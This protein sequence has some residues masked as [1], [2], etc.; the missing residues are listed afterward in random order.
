MKKAALRDYV[1]E[2]LEG[3]GT[4]TDLAEALPEVSR[5]LLSRWYNGTYDKN[6]TR[7]ENKLFAYFSSRRLN[8]KDEI[9]LR[10]IEELLQN[11]EN[12]E[13]ITTVLA[14]RR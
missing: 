6:P 7:I 3:G 11:A 10:R 13:A 4:L 2:Y 12:R 14:L 1:G 5:T 8:V 9:I